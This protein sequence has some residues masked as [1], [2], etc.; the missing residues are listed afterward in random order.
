MKHWSMN[1]CLKD[2]TGPRKFMLTNN[3]ALICWGDISYQLGRGFTPKKQ[4][5]R[6]HKLAEAGDMIWLY[7][8]GNKGGY[9]AYGE[10]TETV[11]VPCTEPIEGWSNTAF[12]YTIPIE[13]NHIPSDSW[14]GQCKARPPTLHE[15]G[16]GSPI[17]GKLDDFYNLL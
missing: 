16:V 13:W 8:N 3:K 14:F 4:V 5:A 7:D 11:W 10:I 9:I 12:Q 6:F 2:G 17:C 1:S 15:I